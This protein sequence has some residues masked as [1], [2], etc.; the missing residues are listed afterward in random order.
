MQLLQILG[1]RL[2]MLWGTISFKLGTA[3]RPWVATDSSAKAVLQPWMNIFPP[4]VVSLSLP[5]TITTTTSA[6]SHD[7]L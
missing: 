7:D 5:P 4:R 1:D 2:G 6:S 3:L